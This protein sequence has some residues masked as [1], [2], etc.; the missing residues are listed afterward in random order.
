MK[1]VSMYFGLS[2]YAWEA[3]YESIMHF[4]NMTDICITWSYYDDPPVALS[5]RHALNLIQRLCTSTG[6]LDIDIGMCRS[7]DKT[8]SLYIPLTITSEQ[9][10]PLL[11]L[12]LFLL[13]FVFSASKQI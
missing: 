7:H 8:N 3:C 12:C 1:D 10:I 9:C 13:L 4:A 11:L 2:F 5:S 6:V